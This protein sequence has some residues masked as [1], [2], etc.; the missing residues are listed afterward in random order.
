M[1]ASASAPPAA[2][3]APA[4]VEDSPTPLSEDFSKWY[5]D[6]IRLCQLADYGPVRGTMVIRPYGYAVWEQIQKHL[7]SEFK[8]TG[9]A[10]SVYAV[11]PYP[12]GHASRIIIAAHLQGTRTATSHSSSRCPSWPR[13]PRTWRG[14]RRSWRS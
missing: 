2:A 14:L 12:L 5:L 3:A 11:R 13:R 7:D 6:V 10:H 8:R 9:A 4:T 1:G